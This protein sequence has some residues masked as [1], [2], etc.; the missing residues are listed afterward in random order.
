M[1][2]MSAAHRLYRFFCAGAIF[3]LICG[4]PAFGQKVQET[5]PLRL[6]LFSATPTEHTDK[7]YPA[8]LYR[9]SADR[10]LEVVREVVSPSEGVR[11]VQ[12]WT[13]AIFATSPPVPAT[14]VDIIHTDDP[15]RED[16]LKFNPMGLNVNNSA[17]V[18]TEPQSTSENQLFP[19]LRDF[20]DPAHLRGSL[21]SVSSKLSDLDSRLKIDTWGEYA[22][23]RHQG[24]QGGPALVAGLIASISGQNLA[25]S[26][27]GHSIVVDGLPPQLRGTG[28]EIV[29]VI[30]CV[31]QQYLVLLL[32]RTREEMSSANLGDT[33]ELFVHD[34]TQDRWRA[35]RADGNSSGFRLFGSWLTT[36]VGMWNPDHKPSPGRENE[37]NSSTN[38]LPNVQEEYATFGG[39]WNWKPGILVLQ[40]LADSRKLK[41]ETGQEDS[42]VL[43]VQADTVLYRINEAIY[44]ARI[45]GD[46]LKD[47]AMIVKDDDVPEIHWVF[48]SK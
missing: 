38:R 26:V 46:Q 30:V 47:T 4:L 1:C 39:R 31:S 45:V 17:T 28:Q 40:N 21:V 19:L 34:R 25:M 15:L 48:W 11:L 32:Q 9:V 29:P 36:I 14:T 22:S 8:V 27:Y 12:A 7:R 24:S 44:Q 33:R 23:L 18:I 16:R 42:E 43:S 37:R 13:N 5:A 2:P 20:S 41:I 6:Y 3:S 10:K 35:L